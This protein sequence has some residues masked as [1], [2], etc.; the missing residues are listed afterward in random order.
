MQL[1][2][3]DHIWRQEHQNMAAAVA[4]AHRDLIDDVF[5]CC[6]QINSNFALQGRKRPDDFRRGKLHAEGGEAVCAL[7]CQ[8]A[9][10]AAL[11]A[12]SYLACAAH[13]PQSAVQAAHMLSIC[14]LRAAAE[15]AL[16]LVAPG[17][18]LCLS[19]HTLYMHVWALMTSCGCCWYC[20]RWRRRQWW[21]RA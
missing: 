13:V 16:V 6:V 4:L 5:S 19:S 11:A 7:S 15:L 8:A 9:L 12:R 17:G 18:C 21:L 10:L 3:G 14:M 2:Q 1:W 20:R